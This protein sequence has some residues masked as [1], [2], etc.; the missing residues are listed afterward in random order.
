[1]ATRGTTELVKT[2]R[3]G[4]LSPFEEFEKWFEGVWGRP[5]GLRRSTMWPSLGFE[6][7][8]AGMPGVDIFEDKGDLVMKADMPGLKKED[9]EIKLTDHVLT[10]SG[11]RKK[12]EKVEKGKY[13]RHERLYGSFLRRFE[14]PYDI[15]TSRVSAHM[16]HGVLE[17]R[18]P[19]TKEAEAKSRSIPISSE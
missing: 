10:V 7:F 6:E 18:L 19:K 12:E 4:Y 11:E 13:F 16:E 3:P 5:F 15:D 17:I 8:E 9:V 14:L 2:E 1:M